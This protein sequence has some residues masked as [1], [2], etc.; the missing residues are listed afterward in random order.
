MVFFVMLEQIGQ[1]AQRVKE[2]RKISGISIDALS[3]ELDIPGETY[4]GYENGSTDIPVS[5]LCKMAIR[6]H[7]DLA[8]LLT[9]A[10]P[11]LHSYCLVRKGKGV[12]VERRH[13]CKHRSLAYNFMQKKAEPFL[14]TVNPEAD[15]EA[16]PCNCHP[17]QEFNYVLEGTLQVVIDSHTLTLHEGDSLF[18]NASLNHGMKALDGKQAMFLAV[19]L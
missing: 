14:V 7:V 6:F 5:F 8:E 3:K 15:H 2:L 9:G 17:G 4:L 10:A 19:I 11:R 16:M 1:V 18:F 12:S 13:Q